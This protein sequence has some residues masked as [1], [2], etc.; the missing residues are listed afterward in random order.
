MKDFLTEKQIHDA[1]EAAK[2][3]EPPQ[4]EDDL[5]AETSFIGHQMDR[6]FNPEGQRICRV[7]LKGA[8]GRL[9]LAVEGVEEKQG[10]GRYEYRRVPAFQQGPDLCASRLSEVRQWIQKVVT[11]K[12]AAAAVP[13][14]GVQEAPAEQTPPRGAKRRSA[15]SA[16]PVA[17]TGEAAGEEPEQ[18]SS[19]K[20][21]QE[22]KKATSKAVAKKVNAT[23]KT[24]PATP[25]KG[26]RFDK[27]Q[28]L[29]QLCRCSEGTQIAYVPG[30]KTAESHKGSYRRYEKYAKATTLKEA[31]EL[32]SGSADIV[33]DLQMGLLSITGNKRKGPLPSAAKMEAE[34]QDRFGRLCAKWL[35]ALEQM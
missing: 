32:G 2:F 9:V 15:A 6:K 18:P 12:G 24:S 23:A 14:E 26:Q 27:K 29:E 19:K 10:T 16:T 7:F 1:K 13:A 31:L 35:A 25:A 28:V 5:P 17:K 30:G 22:P 34:A 3:V 8:S 21:R 4:E 11:A 20:Q 33:Y